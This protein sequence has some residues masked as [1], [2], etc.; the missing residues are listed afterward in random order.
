VSI[1]NNVSHNVIFQVFGVQDWQFFLLKTH[2][3]LN[4]FS[5]PIFLK[6]KFAKF[7]IFATK[8]E[9]FHIDLKFNAIAINLT[10]SSK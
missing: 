9:W 4:F 8:K 10:I 5:F 2:F 7:E 6:M 3:T 1:Y